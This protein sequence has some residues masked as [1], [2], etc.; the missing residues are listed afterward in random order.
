MA[1]PLI[2]FFRGSSAPTDAA[3]GALWFNPSNNEIRVYNGTTW[4]QYSGLVKNVE[5]ATDTKVLTITPFEGDQTSL[6]LDTFVKGYIEA[7]DVTDTAVAGK[8]VSQVTQTDGKI[9]VTRADIPVQ[10]VTAPDGSTIVNS[11]SKKAELS[12]V[13][14]TTISTAESDCSDN[15]FATEKAVRLAINALD[16]A[17]A[18]VEGQYV[19]A[20]SET[21]GVI[22]VTRANL[23]TE[24]FTGVQVEG[25]DLKNVSG[26]VNWGLNYDSVAKQIQVLDRNNGDAVLDSIDATSFVKDGLLYSGELVWCTIADDGTHTEVAE[27]T[28]GA[29]HCLK[30]TLRVYNRD[31]ADSYTEEYVHI[32]LG[33]LCDPYAGTTGQITVVEKHGAHVI[34]LAKVTQAEDPEYK[35]SLSHTVGEKAEKFT[36]VT[37]VTVDDYGRVTGVAT[38]EYT[39]PEIGSATIS[40][41]K[42]GEEANVE[43]SVTTTEGVVTAVSVDASG[44][45]GIVDD[46]SKEVQENA[47]VTAA[48]LVDLNERL[49][50]LDFGVTSVTASTTS[51]HVTVAPTTASDGAVTVTVDVTSVDA[52][53]DFGVEAVGLATDAYVREQ[54]GAAALCWQEGSF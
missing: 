34:G 24:S 49:D 5:Y 14:A 51:A 10:D 50:G 16:K 45:E 22:T 23:P 52:S 19:S 39:M 35:E 30:L 32:P 42:E 54:I 40:S 28:E 6:N 4:E 15:K 31:V 9:E 13:T 18:A 44:L 38:T 43:V 25:V 46:L 47:E 53:A 21:D 8:Y 37:G 7:L 48:A 12:Q 11:E 29:V 36:T 17:D 1:Q 41:V 26:K 2:K 20:V 27:G 33:E 3:I